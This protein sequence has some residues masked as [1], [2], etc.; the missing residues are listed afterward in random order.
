MPSGQTLERS[1]VTGSQHRL[2]TPQ[3]I[4]DADRDNVMGAGDL[5]PARAAPACRVND[6]PCV[7]PWKKLRPFRAPLL[8]VD[9]LL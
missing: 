5:A 8:H 3:Q 1:D 6:C 9:V 7:G 4:Q 2:R